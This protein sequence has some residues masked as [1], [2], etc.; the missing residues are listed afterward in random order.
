MDRVRLGVIGVGGMGEHHCGTFH[1]IPELELTAV[2][3]VDPGRRE[4]VG[5]RFGVP[6][7]ASFPELLAAE[8]IDAVLIATPHY[9]HPTLAAEALR[10]GKHVLC[11]KPIAVTPQQARIGLDEHAEHPDLVYAVMFQMRTSGLYRKVKDLIDSGEI[12]DLV[13]VIW[14]QTDWFRTQAYFDGGGWRATWSGEGGGVLLNQS[15]HG[16]DLLQ[17][18]VGLPKRVRAFCHLGRHHRIEVEDD[19]SAYLEWEN[20][21]TGVL[22]V[23]TGESPGTNR[24]EFIGTRG[25]LVIE[26]GKLRFDRN[27]QPMD[28]VIRESDDRFAVPEHWE[29][30]VPPFPGGGDHSD[31]T[32]NFVRAIL[33]GEKLVCPAREALGALQIGNALMLSSL[34][35]K[36]AEIPFDEREYEDLLSELREKSTF[37]KT[38]RDLADA[39]MKASFH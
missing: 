39:D 27:R 20:G 24:Q 23:S 3:D 22:V 38:T 26:G 14:I 18:F 32:R 36:W 31:L 25:K 13:R 2:C 34:R 16:L 15:P 37:K 6:A 19:V 10:A 11:E 30:E 1:Q 8:Q 9:A 29:M 21:A 5:K 12:G 7:Y 33:H 4:K 28:Q 17:W 35:D